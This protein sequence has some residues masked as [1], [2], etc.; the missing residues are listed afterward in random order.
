MKLRT[1]KKED[2]ERMLEWMHDSFVV[3]K[4][5]GDFYSKT[6]DDCLSFITKCKNSNYIH[7]A[8][9]DNDDKYMGTVS[10]KHITRESAEFAIVL[11]RDAMGKGVSIWAMNEMLRIGFKEYGVSRIYWCVAK[12]NIRALK[13]YDKN[14]FLRIDSEKIGKIEGYSENQIDSYIWYQVNR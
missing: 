12:N 9:A 6:L 1:L 2:A 10:L 5:R 8:I 11:C 14:N 7:M 3:D 13:F 4:L